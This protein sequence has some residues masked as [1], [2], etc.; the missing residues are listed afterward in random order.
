MNKWLDWLVEHE[1]YL[2]V[3]VLAL[4]VALAVQLQFCK[5]P[6][7]PDGDIA[8]RKVE[9]QVE[10]E[11]QQGVS[12]DISGTW[13]MTIPKKRGGAQ[14]WTLKLKQKG[15]QLKGVLTSEGGDLDVTGTLKGQNV[16]LSAKR[17]G[18]TVEFPAV[19]EGEIL[20]GEMKALS[21]RLKWTAK[22]QS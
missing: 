12:T 4:V 15:E 22:R 13:E 10:Q 21:V 3:I 2:V 11:D 9:R 16:D 7:A 18:I 14:V 20:T 8:T 1:K 19:L 5:R 17:F 6:V